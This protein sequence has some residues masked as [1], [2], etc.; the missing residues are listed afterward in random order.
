M[1]QL[2]IDE[3]KDHILTG[4]EIEFSFNNME[5]FSELDYESYGKI[6]VSI[7]TGEEKWEYIFHGTIEEFLLFKFEDKYLCQ[8]YFSK[9]SFDCIL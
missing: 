4:R 2:T 8:D 1:M 5:Y 7:C 6:F 9:I 3:F